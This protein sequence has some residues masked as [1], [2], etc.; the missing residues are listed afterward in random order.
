[1]L[2]SPKLRCDAASTLGGG[3]TI[4]ACGARRVREDSVS[5]SGVGATAVC[6]SIGVRWRL[7]GI[8]SGAGAT[9]VTGSAGSL[10]LA[11]AVVDA[12]GT[13]GWAWFLRPGHDIGQRH[14][15]IQLDVGR[16]DDGL[17]AIVGL[18]RH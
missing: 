14:I 5:T 3:W 4:A 17:G 2:M 16:S 1:M 13:A 11:A 8:V 6:E 7:A 12:R 10:R 9:A 18:G 15:M